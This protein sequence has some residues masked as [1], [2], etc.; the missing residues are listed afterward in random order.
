MAVY[1]RPL[2]EARSHVTLEYLK[3]LPAPEPPTSLK[4]KPGDQ[5]LSPRNGTGRVRDHKSD[6]SKLAAAC[7]AEKRTVRFTDMAKDR[8][9]KNL[10]GSRGS[11]TRFKNKAAHTF[12]VCNKQ[13]SVRAVNRYAM[14]Y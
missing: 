9:R 2:T 3:P 7:A 13:F 4:E 12:E 11:Q 5:V 1:R 14:H 6:L 10:C 8:N